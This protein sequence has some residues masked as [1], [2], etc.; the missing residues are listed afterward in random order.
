MPGCNSTAIMK[1]SFTTAT[2]RSSAALEASRTISISDAVH[3]TLNENDGNIIDMSLS[4]SLSESTANHLTASPIPAGNNKQLRRIPTDNDDSLPPVHRPFEQFHNSKRKNKAKK[5]RS[6]SF[7]QKYHLLPNS[8][9]GHGI[10]GHVHQCIDRTTNQVYAVKTITKSRIRRKDRIQREINLLR[11]VRDHPNIL[12]LHDVYEDDHHVRLVTEMCRGGELFDRIVEKATL[13]KQQ[14][15]TSSND[16]GN[17]QQQEPQQACSAALPA[18]FAEKE[19]AK[20]IHQLLKAVSHL[21]SRNIVHR[22]IKPENIC[23]TD[24]EKNDESLSI[25]LV[26]FGLSIRH[27]DAC[28]PLTSIVGT[29]YYMAPQVLQSA[30]YTKSCDMW[31]IGVITY[32]MLFGRPPFN[33]PT[34]DVI[35]KRIRSGHYSLEYSTSNGLSVYAHD[36]IQC[37]LNMDPAQRWTAAEALEHPWLKSTLG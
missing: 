31:S 17:Q 27:T 37:L 13:S 2:K 7:H 6:S 12:Q 26:D 33:G 25:K 10:A 30:G 23:F 14:A 22:D 28:V 11:E 19:T 36:F 29:S 5:K 18:C 16:H 8:T 1:P 34:D 35:F 24:S 21:H 20:I 32:T 3:V 15:D 9:L 4:Q